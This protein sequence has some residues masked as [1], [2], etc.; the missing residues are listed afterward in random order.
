MN[1]ITYKYTKTA[2]IA[3]FTLILCI[4]C[5][6]KTI[7]INGGEYHGE[8]EDGQPSGYGI[9]TSD[10][11]SHMYKGFWTAGVQN[12]MGTLVNGDYCYKGEFKNNKYDGY[13]ELTLRDSILYTGEWHL[14][15]RS[16]RG[17]IIDSLGRKIIGMWNADTLTS[18]R[19]TDSLGVYIGQLDKHGLAN[20]HGSY[21]DSDGAYYEGHWTNDKRN[22]FG[23]SVSDKHGMRAGEW[24]HDNYKGERVVYTSDRIYGIDISKYQHETTSVV[25]KRIRVR[26]HR[27]RIWKTVKK[28]I[29]HSYPIDWSRVRITHLGT[30]SKKAVSGSADFPITFVYVKSTEGVS[31]RNIY[32]AT[33]CNGARRNGLRVGAYHFFSTLSDP[34]AQAHYFLNH[35]QFHKG[36][37][38]PVLDV[39]PTHQQIIKMGGV[40]VMF[41]RIRTWMRIVGRHVGV[42]PILY[43]SQSFVNRYLSDAPD[44][45]NDYMVWIARYGE[46][47][48][49]VRLIYW[50]LCPDGKVRGV[51]G[52]VDINVFNGYRT[53]LDD[54]MENNCIQ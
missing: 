10:D 9:W 52:D 45:K 27:R 12:G 30:M 47:K 1:N 51:R 38:P 43:V 3:L 8:T 42:R 54:F 13:G 46:Y 32:Y 50:Q 24:R 11:G 6:V 39:E 5:G 34:S 16:G 21:T 41:N 37:F 53:Q 14:G 17:E 40:R 25:T 4:S 19:R 36:D 28:V 15:V 7:R 18:G 35:S 26:R 44:I 22:I 20:G 49:D 2:I 48:P 29:V 23:F 31:I 33:D